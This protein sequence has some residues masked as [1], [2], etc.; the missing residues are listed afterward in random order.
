VGR[1]LRR[2]GLK[3]CAQPMHTDIT[4]IVKM[5]LRGKKRG[6]ETVVVNTHGEPDMVQPVL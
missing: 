3:L 2:V 4:E 5:C 1:E 6:L